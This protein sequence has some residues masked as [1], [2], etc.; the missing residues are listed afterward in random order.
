M[1]SL[2]KSVQFTYLL[3][4]LLTHFSTSPSLYLVF[5]GTVSVND[6]CGQRGLVRTNPTIALNS[7]YLLTAEYPNWKSLCPEPQWKATLNPLSSATIGTFHQSDFACPTWG[8][9][10]PFL[11]TCDDSVFLTKTV[12]PP[13]NPII[14]VAT[15]ILSLDPEWASCTKI[16]DSI[17]PLNPFLFTYGV[18]DPPR[19][20]VPASALTPPDSIK[21]TPLVSLKPTAAPKSVVSPNLPDPTIKLI[22]SARVSIESGTTMAD[23]P[24]VLGPSTYARSDKN[25]GIPTGLHKD[26]HIDSRMKSYSVSHSEPHPDP[27]SGPHPDLR[28]DPHT[29]TRPESHTDPYSVEITDT[30][31]TSISATAALTSE[32]VPFRKMSFS[33]DYEKTLSRHNSPVSN[34]LKGPDGAGSSLGIDIDSQIHEIHDPSTTI[35]TIETTLATYDDGNSVQK[36]FTSKLAVWSVVKQPNKSDSVLDST[37]SQVPQQSDLIPTSNGVHDVLAPSAITNPRH[38]FCAHNSPLPSRTQKINAADPSSKPS[39]PSIDNQALEKSTLALTST[40]TAVTPAPSSVEPIVPIF[41]SEKDM[42]THSSVENRP[43]DNLPSLLSPILE[44]TP[45]SST[46]G[47]L[48]RTVSVAPE[49]AAHEVIDSGSPSQTRMPSYRAP[50]SS[51]NPAHVSASSAATGETR[52]SITASQPNSTSSVFGNETRMQTGTR[53]LARGKGM[54][55]AGNA[56]ASTSGVGNSSRPEGGQGKGAMET[57]SGTAGAEQRLGGGTGGSGARRRV[58]VSWGMVVLVAGVGAVGWS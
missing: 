27:L 10:D 58:R 24:Q 43:F 41:S 2:C 51:A 50:S 29:D 45:T 22:N 13:F 56:S 5:S 18:Y 32:P 57:D 20:L 37:D 9:S 38:A 52:D 49:A 46:S 55:P 11:T 7:N 26:P 4:I 14:V 54:T 53:G 39:K 15:E 3:E 28:S 42:K 48:T 40:G 6:S 44:E 36:Y 35:S 33:Q 19:M 8:L 30:H 1:D 34:T 23:K 21:T 47:R 17:D 12:G 16:E 31:R 25:N